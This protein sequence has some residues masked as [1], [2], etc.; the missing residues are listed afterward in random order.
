MNHTTKR[1]QEIHMVGVISTFF[2]LSARWCAW[3]Q[4]KWRNHPRK[5]LKSTSLRHGLAMLGTNED[6]EQCLNMAK[7]YIRQPFDLSVVVDVVVVRWWVYSIFVYA[8]VIVWTHLSCSHCKCMHDAYILIHMWLYLQRCC[9]AFSKVLS[10]LHNIRSGHDLP[11]SPFLTYSPRLLTQYQFK[12]PLALP[13]KPLVLCTCIVK[14]II[15]IVS[16]VPF[17][18]LKSIFSHKCLQCW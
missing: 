12:Y 10:R 8:R 5:P 14:I 7:L 4:P 15:T 1:V 3:Y 13:I 2:R 9:C 6:G 18:S 17:F 11:L 16:Y